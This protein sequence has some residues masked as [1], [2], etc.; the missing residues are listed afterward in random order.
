MFELVLDLFVEFDG[1]VDIQLLHFLQNLVTVVLFVDPSV[2][3][4][5]F[6]HL[7]FL[8]HLVLVEVL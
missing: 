1:L 8:H 5:Q 7:L 4:V 6:L 2:V 3:F